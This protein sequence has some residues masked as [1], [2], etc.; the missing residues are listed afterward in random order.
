MDARDAHSPHGQVRLIDPSREED[1][2]VRLAVDDTRTARAAG[3]KFARSL[4]G[5]CSAEFALA[6]AEQEHLIRRAVTD[7]G[8]NA[9]QADLAAREFAAAAAVEWQRLVDAGAG[10]AWGRA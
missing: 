2:Q 7:V 8:Y 1:L 3:T 6:L 4:A 5:A 10:A 9:R